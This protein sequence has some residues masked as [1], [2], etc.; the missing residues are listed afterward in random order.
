MANSFWQPVNLILPIAE[1]PLTS[2]HVGCEIFQQATPIIRP[3]GTF[4][5]LI[6]LSYMVQNDPGFPPFGDKTLKPKSVDGS[7]VMMDDQ[8]V[9]DDRNDF[10]AR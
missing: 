2:L 3:G 6:S 5:A 9:F 1:W 8:L 10:K 7:C 4:I